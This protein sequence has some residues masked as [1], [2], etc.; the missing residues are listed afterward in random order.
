MPRLQ[1]HRAL[2]NPLLSSVK[3]GEYRGVRINTDFRASL[4]FLDKK[5][6]YDIMSM[7]LGEKE[8]AEG[9]AKSAAEIFW[10]NEVPDV[11]DI[12]EVL[13][14]FLTMENK[15]ESDG[16]ECF[17][18][19]CDSARIYSDFLQYYGIDLTTAKLHWWKFNSLLQNLPEGSSLMRAIEL[20]QREID[21]N[22]SPTNKA[23]LYKAKEAVMITNHW[24]EDVW[25]KQTAQ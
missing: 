3:D 1:R 16:E 10:N 9:L 7:S 24:E 25:Q 18:Y 4:R 21:K 5:K 8:T 23:K 6:Y 13:T 15:T 17:D 2:W 19:Y 11:P 22:M 20:R 12:M 14:G